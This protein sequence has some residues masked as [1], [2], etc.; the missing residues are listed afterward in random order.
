MIESNSSIRGCFVLSIGTGNDMN[1]TKEEIDNLIEEKIQQGIEKY[2]KTF[3]LFSIEL[4][5][6]IKS[7]N[8]NTSPQKNEIIPLSEWNKYHKYPTVPALRQYYFKRAIN[9]FD[10]VVEYGGNKNGR[11][12][13]NEYK[14]F[15]WL[16]SRK[17]NTNR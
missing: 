11:I 16:K 13:I 14:L 5:N 4:V 2:G 3:K 6:L 15:E 10:K 7:L 8:E 12:L 9:G 1:L 17:N